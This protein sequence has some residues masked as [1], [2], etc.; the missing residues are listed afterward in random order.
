MDVGAVLREVEMWSV[1][2]QV[3]LAQQL[4]DRLEGRGYDPELSDAQKIELDR[5]LA[6]CDANPGAGS[7]WEDVR[8]RLWG[9][10]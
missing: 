7:T 6:E 4:W 9:G 8:A 3:Q 10:S 5:R 2:D 1:K